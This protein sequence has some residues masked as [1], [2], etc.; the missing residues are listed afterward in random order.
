MAQKSE[1]EWTEATWIPIPPS[2]ARHLSL[3]GYDSE[4]ATTSVRF[5]NVEPER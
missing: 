2:T 1:I 5:P 3:S 4:P